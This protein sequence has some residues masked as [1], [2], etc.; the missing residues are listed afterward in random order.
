MNY[1]RFDTDVNEINEI[2]TGSTK[3]DF[4]RPKMSNESKPI[5]NKHENYIFDRNAN[6][7]YQNN[8][9]NYLKPI[10]SRLSDNSSINNKGPVQSSFQSPEYTNKISN[11]I[12]NNN[13]NNYE[14]INGIQEINHYLERNPT[15]TRRDI[16]EKTRNND[17]NE[18]L[19]KQGGNLHNFTDFKIEHTRKDRNSINTNTYIPMG[20]TMSI[21]KE[22]I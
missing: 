3:E 17:T 15:N 16:M 8:S 2:N 19:Q 7:F 14:T 1:R 22:N 9:E 21:P 13:M 12:S 6:L 11:Q 5:N 10:N 20:K 4:W 18:F